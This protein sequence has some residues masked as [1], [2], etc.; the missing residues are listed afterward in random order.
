MTG[1]FEGELGFNGVMDLCPWVEGDENGD[2]YSKMIDKNN[3]LI[4]DDDIPTEWVINDTSHNDYEKNQL[5]I[6]FSE[7][8]VGDM[9][10]TL[11]WALHGLKDDF[12]AKDE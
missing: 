10:E 4:M 5:F 7:K 3:E 1:S 6:V 2:H 9:I 12:K 11:Q 8:E